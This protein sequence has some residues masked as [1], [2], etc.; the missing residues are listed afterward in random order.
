MNKN[1]FI[2]FEGC[3]GSGKSTQSLLFYEQLKHRGI[4]AVHT[5]EPGGTYIAESIRKILLNP[6]NTI[7]PIT[8]LFLYEAARAQHMHD[9]IL[10]ALAA[11][12]VVV[13]DRFTD[14]TVA[15]QGYARG[16]DISIIGLLNKI[17]TDNHVPDI[18]IYLDIPPAKGLTK[19]KAVK[20]GGDRLDR[21]CLSF[22]K[23]V[24]QGYLMAA[25]KEPKRI[26]VIKT[27]KTIQKTQEKIIE[28]VRTNIHFK[29]N[30]VL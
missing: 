9:I 1:L 2:T 19:A 25:R 24:R 8:E 27:A 13:C 3:E 28:T 15:Y 23:K 12:K 18:T 20:N 16:L 17:A 6:R 29:T 7:A 21:E 11:G 10:P 5:R 4:A 30:Y 14:A 26:M 22:H